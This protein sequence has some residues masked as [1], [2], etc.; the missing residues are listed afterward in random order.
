MAKLIT[1]FLFLG[2]CVFFAVGVAQGG[3][4]VQTIELTA[5]MTATQTTM[6][7]DN[8]SG[9]LTADIIIVDG[10]T[11]SYNGIDATHL[12][13]LT[14]GIRDTSATTHSAGAYVYTE[15]TSAIN[16]GIGFNAA[17]LAVRNGWFAAVTIPTRFLFTSIPSMIISADGLF[18][19]ELAILQ[20]FFLAVGVGVY[21]VIALALSQ[22]VAFA[23][24]G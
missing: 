11:I 19:G 3:G 7:V 4:G 10:E 2:I 1:G 14:R 17:S 24:R 15:G 6:T 13:G 9:F 22:I 8:T 5:N 20:Y 16:Q 23:V 12:N 18:S 21:I